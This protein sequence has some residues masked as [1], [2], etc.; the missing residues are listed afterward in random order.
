MGLALC[1]VPSLMLLPALRMLSPRNIVYDNV[2]DWRNAPAD[3]YPPRYHRWVERRLVKS[4]RHRAAVVTDSAVIQQRWERAGVECTTVLPAAD[5]VFVAANWQR[6]ESSR[7]I[8]YFGAVRPTEISVD[9]LLD[10]AASGW[11]VR[12]IGP[13]DDATAA[14]LIDGGISCHPAVSNGE[15]V[16]LMQDWDAVIL[17]YSASPRLATLVPAK[18]FNAIATQRPVHVFGLSLPN[19]VLEVCTAETVDGALVIRGEGDRVPTWA[20][21]WK[22]VLVAASQRPSRP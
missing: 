7:T 1:Y 22:Q 14:T 9:I 2:V 18:L 11:D 6:T 17:P 16:R 20:A 13:T 21:R 3:W 15:L 4:R 19:E 12:V 10:Y 5:D 8:G